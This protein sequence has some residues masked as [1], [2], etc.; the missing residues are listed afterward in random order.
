MG[1]IWEVAEKRVP[2]YWERKENLAI[3]TAYLRDIK[4]TMPSCQIVKKLR[5]FGRNHFKYQSGKDL[6]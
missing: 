1:P 2:P 6:S 3:A 4:K 5:P